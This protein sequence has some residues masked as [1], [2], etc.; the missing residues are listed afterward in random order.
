MYEKK[1]INVNNYSQ[2]LFDQT[3]NASFKNIK[4]DFET[5]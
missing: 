5:H 4:S 3:H 2:Q 1:A